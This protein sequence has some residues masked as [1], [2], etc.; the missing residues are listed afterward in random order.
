MADYKEMYY[1]LFNR[2]TDLIEEM[3]TIQCE[4]EEKYMQGN[5]A[6]IKLYTKTKDLEK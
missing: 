4:M 1:Y 6:E 3:K 2:I 5:E